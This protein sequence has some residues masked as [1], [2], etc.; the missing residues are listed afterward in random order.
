MVVSEIT[1]FN[2]LRQK[3]G[4]QE[5]LVV[6]EGNKNAVKEEFAVRKEVL[7]TKQDL[8]EV[9]AEIIKWMFIFWI[10]TIGVLSGILFALLN[11]YLK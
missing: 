10:G 7:A 3:L 11:A 6:V 9:K 1:L 8:S 4:E 2:T 5:A